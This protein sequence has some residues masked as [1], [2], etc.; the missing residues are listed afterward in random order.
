M[1]KTASCGDIGVSE[2]PKKQFVIF[3]KHVREK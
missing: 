3:F 2:K 1:K